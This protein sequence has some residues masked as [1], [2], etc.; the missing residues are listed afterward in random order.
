MKPHEAWRN[1]RRDLSNTAWSAIEL[2]ESF[3]AHYSGGRP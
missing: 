1:L 2:F 3:F